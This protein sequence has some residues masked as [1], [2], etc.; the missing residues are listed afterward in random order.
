MGMGRP[1]AV[2]WISMGV[3]AVVAGVTLLPLCGAMFR[4]GCSL[5]H[6]AGQC[7]M[8]DAGGPH[9]PWCAGGWGV[10]AGNFGPMLVG[11]VAG[12]HAGIRWVR[13]TVWAGV[14]GGGIGYALAGLVAGWV[15]T[16]VVGYPFWFGWG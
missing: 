11:V 14:A 6:G 1:R 4:C 12:V 13:A 10:I 16:R 5:G 2:F 15:T 7:N 3:T 8:H 9:C